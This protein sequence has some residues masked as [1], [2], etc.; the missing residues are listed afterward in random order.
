MPV[1]LGDTLVPGEIT[2]AAYVSEPLRDKR[3]AETG[4]LAGAMLEHEP[5]VVFQ[6]VRGLPDERVER[7]QSIGPGRE[8]TSGFV[9]QLR[10]P[11]DRVARI[12]VRWVGYDELEAPA[13]DRFEP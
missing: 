13:R 4:S 12:D 2:M 3:G 6:E 10:R 7:G 1:G 5:P 11:E 8:G 9:T